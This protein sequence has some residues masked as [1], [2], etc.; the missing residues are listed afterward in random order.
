MTLDDGTKIEASSLDVIRRA[1]T[2]YGMTLDRVV[3]SG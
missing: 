3:V 1:E 2:G